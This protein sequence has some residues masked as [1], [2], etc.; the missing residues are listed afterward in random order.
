MNHTRTM[1][2][3]IKFRNK[4]FEKVIQKMFINK[5][6]WFYFENMLI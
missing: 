3:S 2:P 4:I 1:T 6:M 5:R